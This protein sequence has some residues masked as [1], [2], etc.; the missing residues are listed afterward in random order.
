MPQVSTHLLGSTDGYTTQAHSPD[1]SAPEIRELEDLMHG[2]ADDPAIRAG[3]GNRPTALLRR[4]Q[5]S[6]RYAISRILAGPLDSTGRDTIVV[7]TIVLD[8]NAF[9]RTAAG[10]MW[11]LL[12]AP[13]LWQEKRFRE[14]RSISLSDI[15][16]VT[17][18]VTQNDALLFDTWVQSRN[19]A[20]GLG[21]IDNAEVFEQALVNLGQVLHPEDRLAYMWGC[22]LLS[23]QSPA[24]LASFANPNVVHRGRRSV[25]QPSATPQTSQGQT[26]LQSV[27]KTQLPSSQ[28]KPTPAKS[29]ASAWGDDQGDIGLEGSLTPAA[30][31]GTRW[32]QPKPIAQPRPALPMK[33]LAVGAASLVVL[34]GAVLFGILQHKHNQPPM[35]DT[36]V[37]ATTDKLETVEI[38]WVAG[39]G[40]ATH[41][42]ER[43]EASASPLS[44]E[45]LGEQTSPF[46]DKTGKPGIKYFYRVTP[47]SLY[48]VQ[49]EASNRTE[50]FRT[51]AVPG[52]ITVT[53]AGKQAR[54]KWDPVEGAEKYSVA[55]VIDPRPASNQETSTAWIEIELQPGETLASVK[56]VAQ[57]S[58]NVP[59]QP[60]PWEAG[61][62]QT[63]TARPDAIV[64]ESIAFECV[65]SQSGQLV[66]LRVTW[67]APQRCDACTYELKIDSRLTPTSSPTITTVSSPDYTIVGV[68]KYETVTV[69]ITVMA[70]DTLGN[71]L[72]SAKAK[73]EWSA[74][75]LPTDFALKAGTEWIGDSFDL[76]WTRAA[77]VNYSVKL[78]DGTVLPQQ[79]EATTA[80]IPVSDRTA[81]EV[82]L[83]LVCEK[84]GTCPRST[85]P[86]TIRRTNPTP[87]PPVEPT[88]PQAMKESAE[89]Y[90]KI[91]GMGKA[92]D[93]VTIDLSQ[94]IRKSVGLE[95][96]KEFSALIP[97]E[98]NRIKANL[99]IWMSC[100]C[101]IARE[102][103]AGLK[104]DPQSTEPPKTDAKDLANEL[105]ALRKAHSRLPELLRTKDEEAPQEGQNDDLCEFVSACPDI[106]NTLE[107]GES[108]VLQ[109]LEAQ[110]TPVS[111]SDLWKDGLLKLKD[112]N[113][114][115][116]FCKDLLDPGKLKE[117]DSKAKKDSDFA[118]RLSQWKQVQYPTWVDLTIYACLLEPPLS[119]PNRSK[120]RNAL[121]EVLK[122]SQKKGGNI[123]R[124][125]LPFI[126]YALMRVKDT[127][128]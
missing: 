102:K 90:L 126:D 62:T 67:P 16:P 95:G 58:E 29:L 40:A 33:W 41:T 68:G 66:D 117:P 13:N 46:R 85:K 65:Q 104:T 54:I 23:P 99:Q 128:P 70:T 69:S 106:K 82:T 52:A 51:L 97:S 108:K 26:A 96:N 38:T 119:Q 37:T 111:R 17:R 101:S 32:S 93:S 28:A 91:V 110:N 7:C 109:W 44:W 64:A 1:L 74:C 125:T 59:S 4:L 71:Q 56:V 48:G 2:Q 35:P 14:G 116:A 61:F 100:L 107:A 75:P 10:D 87:P 122:D 89:Q 27:G 21:V 50:G 36:Q 31:R 83:E 103:V 25:V 72:S 79:A 86:I 81:T 30:T 47:A 22:H 11:S 19:T 6:G 114:S 20:N 118:Y 77:D 94:R 92:S 120:L 49:G 15:P 121:T 73:A 84:L 124:E 55:W 63:K 12:N 39:E 34:A 60:A 24:Q 42:V 43:S 112:K 113:S 115:E 5:S 123:A 3:L 8:P 57:S 45:S 78:S 105:M 76:T 80:T 18:A 88:F 9:A 127:N 53:G 98:K